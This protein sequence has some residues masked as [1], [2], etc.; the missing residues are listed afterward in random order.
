[1]STTKTYYSVQFFSPLCT[2][3]Q[4]VEIK[5]FESLSTAYEY[6]NTQYPRLG[7]KPKSL[8]TGKCFSIQKIER[9]VKAKEKEEKEGL[10]K[11]KRP[12]PKKAVKVVSTTSESS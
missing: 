7:L 5:E 12:P 1:M 3:L 10:V 4:L 2:Q 6:F 11:D 9:L 8:S